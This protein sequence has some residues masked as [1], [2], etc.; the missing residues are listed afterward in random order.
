LGQIERAVGFV[1]NLAGLFPEVRHKVD[2]MEIVDEYWDRAGAPSKTI[3]STDEAE[4]RAASRATGR[5]GCEAADAAGKAAPAGRSRS[6]PPNS[7]PRRTRADADGR[8]DA[9]VTKLNR[10][11]TAQSAEYRDPAKALRNLADRLRLAILA[12]ATPAVSRCSATNSAVRF[13]FGSA[14]PTIISCSALPCIASPENW[15]HTANE[16]RAAAQG[17]H[18]GADGASILPQIFVARDSN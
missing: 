8:S 18:D 10:H 11:R 17:G 7:W 9:A 12:I 13:R 1:G 16:R 6:T 2:A 4:K 15:K 14:G 3:R 5:A